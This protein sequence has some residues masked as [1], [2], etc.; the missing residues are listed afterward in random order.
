MQ[1]EQG[2][3]FFEVDSQNL[4]GD[5]WLTY[6]GDETKGQT[7]EELDQ[8]LEK[9]TD[10]N[11]I[12]IEKMKKNKAP[13]DVIEEASQLNQRNKEI[14]KAKTVDTIDD[15]EKEV[16]LNEKRSALAS[17]K[18]QHSFLQRANS[19]FKSI[20]MAVYE[21]V[22]KPIRMLRKMSLRDDIRALS[23]IE[24]RKRVKEENIRIKCTRMAEKRLQRINRRRKFFKQPYSKEVVFTA[25]E[26]M[27][28]ED[29]KKLVQ[30]YTDLIDKTKEKIAKLDAKAKEHNAYI[31]DNFK[32]FIGRQKP[33]IEKAE[34]EIGPD[35]S[36][37]RDSI[38]ALQKDSGRAKASVIKS[39]G[40]TR[41][42]AVKTKTEK[43]GKAEKSEKSEKTVLK[44]GEWS[45]GQ[46]HVFQYFKQ[47]NKNNMF[48]SRRNLSYMPANK[49][50][51]VLQCTSKMPPYLQDPD[52][53]YHLSIPQ[54][55]SLEPKI[56]EIDRNELNSVIDKMI[57]LNTNAEKAIQYK[58]IE[59]IKELQKKE[60]DVFDGIEPE[61]ISV[62]L[63][64]KE[65]YPNSGVLAEDI[66]N[67]DIKNI[68]RSMELLEHL[69]K[70]KD[71]KEIIL[72]MDEKQLKEMKAAMQLGI[73]QRQANVILEAVKKDATTSIKN[74]VKVNFGTKEKVEKQYGTKDQV[75]PKEKKEKEKELVREKSTKQPKQT[76]E[77]QEKPQKE[78]EM[79]QEEPSLE[80]MAEQYKDMPDLDQIVPDPELYN[81]VE[82][83]PLGAHPLF[84]ETNKDFEVD[85]GLLDNF[86]PE[87]TK[88]SKGKDVYT[89]EKQ[90][91]KVT[92]V[93]FAEDLN[94][95]KVSKSIERETSSVPTSTDAPTKPIENTQPVAS[96]PS[97]P[98]EKEENITSSTEIPSFDSRV[99]K[100]EKD[101][102]DNKNKTC[103]AI[104][105]RAYKIMEDNI[106]EGKSF[107]FD[108]PSGSYKAEK[109]EDGLHVYQ[110]SLDSDTYEE[111]PKGQVIHDFSTCTIDVTN[112]VVRPLSKKEKT[113]PDK[114]KSEEEMERER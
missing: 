34:P 94:S 19:M 55:Q 95:A 25:Y 39:L 26:K 71:T 82:Q 9:Y 107:E 60:F 84:D 96:V 45:Q 14:L 69:P 73:T 12:E 98:V 108:I 23:K 70:Q 104:A 53:L 86:G 44:E 72:S 2:V 22:A 15:A 61:K 85:E 4:E 50:A 18:K 110:F 83:D 77:E 78:Q 51:W 17:A 66:K 113:A 48:L 27:R 103:L 40:I 6:V 62:Y 64:A 106:Q 32:A 75:N 114:E 31:K 35:K 90:T 76:K 11:E 63:N 91:E 102:E 20:G 111:I 87:D 100:A 52:K 112:D 89:G 24:E 29:A 16:I 3:D 7:E 68:H 59:E 105:K 13:E 101:F 42:E 46:E 80:Q 79:I 67:V 109:E 43:A 10:K 5:K 28:M 88:K 58:E 97:A 33:V 99:R 74:M 8:N 41:L 93:E 81:K 57:E 47:H 92:D 65:Q 36:A 38:E 37:E 21:A 54:L 1:Q 30:R 56:K 49:M